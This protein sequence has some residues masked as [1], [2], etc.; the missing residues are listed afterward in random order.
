[1]I[2]VIGIIAV[3]IGIAVDQYTKYLAITHLQGNPISIIDGVFELRYLENRGAAFGLL[4]NQQAFF[5]IIGCITLTFIIYLYIRLPQTKR[6][7]LL[8]IC[9]ISI[10]SGAIGNMIDRIRFH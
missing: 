8:R 2:Y 1:M 10:T 3:I 5:L 7:L 6:F 4:Q 9:M